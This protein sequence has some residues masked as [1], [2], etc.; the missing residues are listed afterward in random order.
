MYYFK[1]DVEKY[2]KIIGRLE[3][4]SI[5]KGEEFIRLS[6]PLF[7][8]N[9][10]LIENKV[11]YRRLRQMSL[12]RKTI[13]N[14]Q[15]SKDYFI[16]YQREYYNM[17]IFEN[18][19]ADYRKYF[20]R[21]L[22]D[23]G[24]LFDQYSQIKN[25]YRDLNDITLFERFKDLYLKDNTRVFTYKNL[26]D[27]LDTDI[28]GSYDIL[29]SIFTPTIA[30]YLPL[31]SM[32]NKESLKDRIK[33]FFETVD[34]TQMNYVIPIRVQ[35]EPLDKIETDVT[36]GFTPGVTY[37]VFD[38]GVYRELSDEELLAG[39]QTGISYFVK[40]ILEAYSE[41]F[42]TYIEYSEFAY[43]NTKYRVHKLQIMDLDETTV[44]HEYVQ[45][46][47]EDGNYVPINQ[48]TFDELYNTHTFELMLKYDV[49]NKIM[50]LVEL[51]KEL[52]NT[53]SVYEIYNTV[54]TRDSYKRTISKNLYYR[55]TNIIIP[56]L[57]SLSMENDF[58]PEDNVND[59]LEYFVNMILTSKNQKDFEDI[60]K[61]FKNVVGEAFLGEEEQLFTVLFK[62]TRIKHQYFY[63]ILSTGMMNPPRESVI[64]QYTEN[65]M[66][67]K[68]MVNTPN[69]ETLTLKQMFGVFLVITHMYFQTLFL[70][71]YLS[72]DRRN[73]HTSMTRIL[74]HLEIE[75]KMVVSKDEMFNQIQ[76]NFEAIN[77]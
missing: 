62:N 5:F 33:T 73:I 64:M 2:Q 22:I 40:P 74:E 43:D 55:I 63:N 66:L 21:S 9:N 51:V 17:P 15:S 23:K 54:M 58:Q 36:G 37:Y 61:Y 44:I 25:L 72:Q 12:R 46:I 49:I 18:A 27:I 70:T 1:N 67:L 14:P 68:A 4:L 77:P 39:P 76:T 47:D 41:T 19:T 3:I 11:I 71:S 10:D 31:F 8:F 57:M 45:E 60:Q 29:S 16:E 48:E 6:S 35:L 30:N 7:F 38:N 24:T 69:F 59:V 32:Y 75:Y 56:L 20:T 42:D 34:R 50:N 53:Y 65:M 13:V 52:T 28:Q 26:D